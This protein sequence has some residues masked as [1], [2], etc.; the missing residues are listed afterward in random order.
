MVS[1]VFPGC[2][3]S[4]SNRGAS[5]RTTL[6]LST[7][8]DQVVL[9]VSFIYTALPG[10]TQTLTSAKN[11]PLPAPVPQTTSTTHNSSHTAALAPAP[12]TTTVPRQGYLPPCRTTHRSYGNTSQTASAPPPRPSSSP[13]PQVGRSGPSIRD[14]V[15][16]CRADVSE[17][18]ARVLCWFFGDS[19]PVDR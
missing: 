7:H 12:R 11:P 8:T 5:P 9:R 19:H 3:V 6:S 10:T 2:R 14:P 17:C 16:R 4:R 13:R 15:C 18:R 1:F